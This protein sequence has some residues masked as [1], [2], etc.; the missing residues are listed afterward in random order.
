MEKQRENVANSNK[1]RQKIDV[2]S[3]ILN[4]VGKHPNGVYSPIVQ[5]FISKKLNIS[6]RTVER[7]ISK[8]VKHGILENE[9]QLLK[10]LKKDKA[11]VPL[12]IRIILSE[13]S[14]LAEKRFMF[15][16]AYPE[17]NKEIDQLDYNIMHF[18]PNIPAK[19]IDRIKKIKKISEEKNY[20][21]VY[22]WI[23][24]LELALKKLKIWVD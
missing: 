23:S 4:I 13:L 3:E 22:E 19:E 12:N 6:E 7:H 24:S 5:T 2:E 15:R 18:Y 17:V 14:M 10:K 11:E 8:L 16:Y 20:S 1:K 21:E 9:N